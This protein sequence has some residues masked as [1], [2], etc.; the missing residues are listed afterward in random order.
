MVLLYGLMTSGFDVFLSYFNCLVSMAFATSFFSS[1]LVE[2]QMTLIRE[3]MFW[4][5]DLDLNSF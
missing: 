1:Y 2:Q 4:D 3:V 5:G